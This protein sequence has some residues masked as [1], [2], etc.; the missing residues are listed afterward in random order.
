MRFR[1]GSRVADRPKP[2]TAAL[3]WPSSS[4]QVLK[5]VAAVAGPVFVAAGLVAVLAANGDGATPAA[6]ATTTTVTATREAKAFQTKVDDAFRPLADAVRIFL[7]VAQEFESGTRSPG[8]LAGAVELA[9][10]EFMRVREA[11]GALDSYD[12]APVVNR[13]FFD[14][15]AL[16]VETGHV[17]R[18]A[19]EP[20]TE[21]LR[22]QLNLVA[23]RLRTL[24]DRVYDRGRVALDPAFYRAASGGL[25]FRPPTEVPDWA[26]EGMAAGPPLAEPPGPPA[27]TP[28][29]RQETCS[30]SV[31]GPCRRE[32]P[33]K[34]WTN[35]V[36]RT[37]VP[38]PSDVLRA[39]ESADAVRLGE[40]A[41]T[42]ESS[43]RILRAGPDPEGDRERA[44]VL[45]L[46]FLAL[47]EAARV[48]QIAALLP[49]G[50]V[51]TRLRTIARRVLIIG[52]S[53][54]EPADLGFHLSGLPRSVL[55]DTWP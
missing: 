13:Y 48:S 41:G 24:A 10:P 9:L 45:A 27:A 39:M 28:P 37:R 26:A 17:Y 55:T 18:I 36:N 19:A 7:P 51:S 16:Y 49:A 53:L 44:A 8:D 47:G 1:T 2:V 5:V 46:G 20:G 25:D 22:Q 32:E 23:R 42:Y 35:R 33:V 14:A 11:I 29:V 30:E 3:S 6:T 4:H 52:D 34:K 21:P 40:L 50:E 12:A 15:A 38:Q 31:A 43:T 54:V